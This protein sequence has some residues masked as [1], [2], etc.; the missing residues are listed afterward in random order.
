MDDYGVSPFQMMRILGPVIVIGP[1][2]V[3]MLVSGPFVLYPIARWRQHRSGITDPQLGLKSALEYFR[4]IAF[5]LGLLGALMIVYA[6]LSKMPG[7]AK[8]DLYRAGFGLFVPTAILFAVHH[9]M[10]RTTNQVQFTGPRRLFAGYNLVITGLCGMVAFILVFEALFAKGSSGDFGRF[11]G[12]AL[13]VY[14]GAWAA[15][16]IQF[17]T[18][19]RDD[20]TA[21]PPVP[22]PPREVAASMPVPTPTPGLPSL[23]GGAFPPVDKT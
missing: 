19:V 16:G 3:A 9:A 5:Q 21:P 11:A 22:L 6:M 15:C 8:G 14:G 7:D 1:V 2:L 18:L 23:G 17:A 13:V 4:M 20:T 12:A 10:L